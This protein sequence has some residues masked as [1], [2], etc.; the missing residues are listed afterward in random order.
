[1]AGSGPSKGKVVASIN[2]TPLVDVVLVLLIIFMVTATYIARQAF[3]A[4]LPT[5]SNA[6]PLEANPPLVIEVRADRSLHVGGEALDLAGL[7]ARIAR[8]DGPGGKKAEQAVIAADKTVD[9]G[10]VTEVIDTLR[11]GGIQ[12]F[13]LEI[14]LPPKKPAAEDGR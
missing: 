6:D 5:A 3:E 4:D 10:R 2:V 9:Y 1:M 12:K 8:P 11:R 14:R 13:A 7:E